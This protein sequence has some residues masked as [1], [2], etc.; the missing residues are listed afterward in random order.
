[1]GVL[2]RRQ[3]V[4]PKLLQIA[5]LGAMASGNG[6]AQVLG[7]ATGCQVPSVA[8]ALRCVPLGIRQQVRLTLGGLVDAG[9]LAA[10]SPG[11][12]RGAA[13]DIG[14]INPEFF[15]ESGKGRQRLPSHSM[16]I[17]AH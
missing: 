11:L 13:A 9:Q 2:H 16:R 7:F 8:I 17:A 10:L 5:P 3:S 6:G 15:T 12:P 1:M 14:L 4:L